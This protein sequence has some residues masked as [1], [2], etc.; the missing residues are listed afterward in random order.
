[1]VREHRLSPMEFIYLIK[2]KP[3]SNDAYNM[4]VYR[5][6]K[7][8][9]NKIVDYYTLSSKGVTRYENNVPIEFV[10]LG[11]WLKERDQFNM[12]KNLS[13]FKKFRKWKTL[14]KW[15]KVLF[16]QRSTKIQE[17]LNEKLYILDPIYQNLLL[18]H[19][20]LCYDFERLRFVDVGD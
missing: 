16:K 9:E 15:V 20:S 17:K 4:K 5:Y 14:K 11:D 8:A 3:N 12:I 1:M 18:T 6:D 19:K 13:F 10:P 2:E 7:L